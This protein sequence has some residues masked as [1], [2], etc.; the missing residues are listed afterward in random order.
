LPGTKAHMIFSFVLASTLARLLGLN[1]AWIAASAILASLLDAFIDLGHR[2]YRR[3]AVTHSIALAP[4]PLL[5]PLSAVF[6]P[7]LA[8][9]SLNICA[10]TSF[11]LVLLSCFLGHL[12]WDSLTVNGIHVPGMGWVSLANL[13]SRSAVANAMPILLAIVITLLFWH[14]PLEAV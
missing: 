9:A 5:A 6:L 1:A 11:G 4:A 7:H 8:E 3:S 13:E 14:F 10:L 12:F 2:G